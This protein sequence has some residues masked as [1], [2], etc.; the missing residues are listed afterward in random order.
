[1]SQFIHKPI[2]IYWKVVL[3]IL[4]HIKESSSRWVL[5]KKYGHLR[6]EAFSYSN[7]VGDKRDRKSTSDYCTYLEVIQLLKRVRSRML[8]LISV[9]KQ[10]IELWLI[11]LVRWYG[12]NF[13]MVGFSVD[14]SMSMYYD[15]HVVIYIASNSIF[16]ERTKHIE[17][18]SHFVR[19]AVSQKLIST[20]FIIF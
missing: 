15:N 17:V 8:Y 11:Q 6:I 19:D 12:W 4:T 18:D 10:S 5:Y 16:H 3:R 1:M 14:G 9:L 20:L 7:Y 2:E 13:F